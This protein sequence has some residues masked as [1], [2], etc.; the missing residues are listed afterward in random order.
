[1]RRAMAAALG[2][3]L[4]AAPL[5]AASQDPRKPALKTRQEQVSYAMAVAM[6]RSV[7]RQGVEL[8]VHA[9]TLGMQDVLAGRELRMS[10]PEMRKALGGVVGD[11]ERKRAAARAAGAAAK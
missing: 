7:Q 1:M 3:A 10:Q 5:A 2:W 9:F 6:A 8:D 4:L 11:L